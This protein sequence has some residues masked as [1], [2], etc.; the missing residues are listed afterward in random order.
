[1]SD[2][3]LRLLRDG[4]R[5]V[6]RDRADRGGGTTYVSRMLGRRAV[7]LGG[8]AGARVF[9]D[10]AVVERGGAIPPPLGWLLFGRG[11][12]HSLDDEEHRSRK[13]MFLG[14]LGPQQVSACADLAH[15]RLE[16]V[17]EGWS[18]RDV[19][20][21]DELVV[22]YGGA[23]LQWVGVD[24]AELRLRDLSRRYATIVDGFGFA[25][26]F[27]YARAWAARR[28][29]DRW[30][31]DLVRDVRAGTTEAAPGTVLAA[32]AA[33][34]LDDRTAAVELGNVVRPTTA[35]SWLGVHAAV[36]LAEADGDLR[37]R[38][39]DPDPA[40]DA[41]RWSFAQEVRRTT[42][43]VP[44]LAGRVRSLTTHDGVEL[45]P[46]DHVVLDVRGIDLDDAHYP[47]PVAFRAARF[48]GHE[49]GA[50]DLVPQGGGPPDG[51]RCPGESLT[52]Q[53]L[54]RTVLVLA[55]ADVPIAASGD[56]AADLRRI[57]TR[58]Q[59]SVGG[60]SG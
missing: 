24:L 12:V 41:L 33:S 38:L 49:P 20:L 42:P 52:L 60:S 51:H 1:M 39:A 46:G 14:L 18:G 31:R 15:Q 8:E 47:D 27:V 9:Y 7:V 30:A 45:R 37:R 56:H 34:D 4:Y 22:A 3:T 19:D 58:P 2:L 21:H 32:I 10:E 43:F 29:T 36:A 5:A 55:G 50:Y 26:P 48:D 44:A 59:V 23:V 25:G 35:V 13:A 53:L 16:H 11:A 28:A 17:A 40:H 54:V 57:P 6:E